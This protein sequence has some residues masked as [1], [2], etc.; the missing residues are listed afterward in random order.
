M[1]LLPFQPAL[2]LQ[3]DSG[4]ILSQGENQ[5]DAGSSEQVLFMAG[6]IT[7]LLAIAVMV[8]WALLPG[9]QSWLRLP[10]ILWCLS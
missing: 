4:K 6:Y 2:V 3:H 7:A 9:L 5:K 1:G 8:R 10:E